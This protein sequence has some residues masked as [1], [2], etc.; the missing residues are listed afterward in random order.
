[1]GARFWVVLAASCLGIAIG[2]MILFWVIGAAL[3]AWGVVGA[4]AVLGG[5]LLLVAWMH[6]RREA[7]Y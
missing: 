5:I 2:V 7:R 4:F 1:M 3:L 6:D